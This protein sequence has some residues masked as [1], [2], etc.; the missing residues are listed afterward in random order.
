M[1]FLLQLYRDCRPFPVAS[2]SSYAARSLSRAYR[3]RTLP[4]DAAS[5]LTTGCEGRKSHTHCRQAATYSP[6]GRPPY[7]PKKRSFKKASR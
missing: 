6:R 3:W 5:R 4:S 1:R 2:H 7:A